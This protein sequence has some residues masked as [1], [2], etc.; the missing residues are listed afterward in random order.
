MAEFNTDADDVLWS[1]FL[2]AHSLYEKR[3]NA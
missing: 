1:T 2:S 3:L